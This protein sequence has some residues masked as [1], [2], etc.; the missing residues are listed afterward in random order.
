MKILIH[1]LIAMTLYTSCQKA[2]S[3]ETVSLVAENKLNVSYGK[4]SAQRMDI[5]LPAGR[6]AATTPCIVLIHGGGWSS[7]DK[8]DLQSYIDTFK[9]RLPGY[10]IFN[11]NYRLASANHIFPAQELDI[12]AA[13]DH[14]LTN[15]GHYG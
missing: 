7:G 8:T 14:I 6:S 4:D 2:K 11:L 12:K 13:V 10:A 1:L 5:Y 3:N 9:K 15:A